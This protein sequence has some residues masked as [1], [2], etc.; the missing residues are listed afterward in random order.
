[1]L[2]TFKSCTHGQRPCVHDLKEGDRKNGQVA[3]DMDHYWNQEVAL[4][5]IG[6][7]KH[8]APDDLGQWKHPLNGMRQDE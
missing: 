5:R 6:H 3:Q 7:G 1:M 2:F 8:D 4:P